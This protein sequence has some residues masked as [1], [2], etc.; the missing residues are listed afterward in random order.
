MTSINYTWPYRLQTLLYCA[1]IFWLSSREDLPSDSLLPD[2]PGI[3]KIIHAILYAGLAAVISIGLRRS[4]ANLRPGF[5]FWLPILFVILYGASDELHQYFVPT[6]T[7]D[8]F[9]LLADT[10]GACA[11]Q[12]ILCRA[13]WK[14]GNTPVKDSL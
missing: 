1:A 11:I 10:V 6:R 9:D 4:N 8:P 3:D 14:I 13:L 7:A 12:F 5:Q 2:I